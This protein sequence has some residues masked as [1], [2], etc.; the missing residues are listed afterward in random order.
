M[1]GVLS[2]NKPQGMTS[3]DVVNIVRRVFNLRKVGHLGTLDPMTTGILPVCLG[4]ATRLLPYFATD[5]VYTATL[6]LGHTTDSWDADGAILTTTNASHLGEATIR[7]AFTPLIGEIEQTIPLRSA[8]HVRGKKLYQYA[9]EG[10]TLTLP[11]KRVTIHTLDI[12]TCQPGNMPTVTFQVHCSTGTY[13]RSIAHHVGEQ[14]GVGGYLTQLH[15][16]RHGRF[17][18]SVALETLQH[19]V[20]PMQYL[21]N[22]LPYLALPMLPLEDDAMVLT[23][24]QG[25]KLTLPDKSVKTNQQLVATW[26]QHP[27]AVVLAEAHNQV[28]PQKVFA[29]DH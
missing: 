28:K 18:E 2:I 21:Q 5:K 15:R 22:P 4:G 9:I 12:L 10:K 11:T 8:K 20:N 26:Q 3:H 1:F 6:R 19:D 27:V 14:L 13:I 24:T 17:T 23:L 16:D 7:A 25:K 29:Y